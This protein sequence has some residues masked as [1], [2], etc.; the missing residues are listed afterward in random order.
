ML[1][2]VWEVY[3][4]SSEIVPGVERDCLIAS[5]TAPAIA[6]TEEGVWVG[7]PPL[8]LSLLSAMASRAVREGVLRQM[9]M[10]RTGPYLERARKGRP[11]RSI[12]KEQ[13]EYLRKDL[14]FTWDE[15]A[16][17]LGTSAKTLQRR[18]KDWN[19]PRYSDMD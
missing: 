19:I 4:A 13:L 12:D 9:A 5:A 17:L 3:E 18:A 10:A 8:L 14:C 15:T 7:I 6:S 11:K 16:A 2:A 1:I